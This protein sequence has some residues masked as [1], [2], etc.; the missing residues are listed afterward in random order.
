MSANASIARRLDSPG[1]P[2]FLRRAL[3]KVSR[4]EEPGVFAPAGGALA[5]GEVDQA[6]PVGVVQ[7]AGVRQKLGWHLPRDSR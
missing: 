3:S 7:L 6:V 4:L 2:L 5:V 1:L